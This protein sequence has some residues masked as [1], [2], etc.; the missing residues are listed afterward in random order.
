MSRILFVIAALVLA[1]GSYLLLCQ[2][3]AKQL[4]TERPKS[5]AEGESATSLSG[6]ENLELHDQLAQVR[7]EV[8]ALRAQL[9]ATP[10]A[11]TAPSEINAVDPTAGRRDPEALAEQQQVWHEQMAAVET[12]F[13]GERRDGRWSSVTEAAVRDA[14]RSDE[15]LHSAL[16]SVDC[17]AQTCR[18]EIADDGT[19]KVSRDLP[20]FVADLAGTLPQ[21]K[22]DTL[23]EGDGRRT[24]VMY[25]SREGATTTGP[26]LAHVS[27]R[28]VGAQR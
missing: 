22:T 14:A 13:R 10:P 28:T 21:T 6:N 20:K 23:D 11:P 5:S 27:F 12:A 1:I 4:R 9:S 17:R 25:L 7:A 19:H 16:R 15:G 3:D 26:E 2:P 24:M 18:V 8:A